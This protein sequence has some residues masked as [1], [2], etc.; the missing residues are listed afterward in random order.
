M[1]NKKGFTLVELLAVIAI[2]A[3]LVIIALPNV[4]NMYNNARK[5]VFLTEA[6]SVA[7]ASE[8]K[9]LSNSISGATKESIY[10]KSKTDEKNPLEMTGA[11]KYYY[12]ELGNDGKTKKLIIWDDQK[13]IKY[14]ADGSKEISNLTVDEV[15]ERDNSNFTCGNVLTE[16]GVKDETTSLDKNV[17]DLTNTTWILDDNYTFSFTSVILE[18]GTTSSA[19]K[20]VDLSEVNINFTSNGR[21]FI[22]ITSLYLP[23]DEPGVSLE[24]SCFGFKVSFSDTFNKIDFPFGEKLES[25]NGAI[26]YG[27]SES[28]GVYVPYYQKNGWYNDNYKTIEITGG[29]DTTKTEVINWFK[30]HGTRIK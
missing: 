17:N 11:K 28:E 9:F 29:T 5:Q 18:D 2:L 12:V 23:F 24:I 27:I 14:V 21:K 20:L 30:K 7:S 22:G 19:N 13:Y 8:K 3:I 16:I 6:Q 15:V 1:K 10:C 26:M 4:I 25:K